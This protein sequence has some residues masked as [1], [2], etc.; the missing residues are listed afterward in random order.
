MQP[1]RGRPGRRAK[2]A[3]IVDPRR[4]QRVSQLQKNG[5]RPPEQDEAFGVQALRDYC[6][7]FSARLAPP[8]LSAAAD[9]HSQPATPTSARLMAP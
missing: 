6:R 7:S 2:A 9:F 8:A 3:V 5:A 1:R 4:D